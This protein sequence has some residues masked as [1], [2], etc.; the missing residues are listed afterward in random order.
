MKKSLFYFNRIVVPVCFLFLFA[1]FN[2]SCSVKSQTPT[3]LTE[4]DNL[5]APLISLNGIVDMND[6]AGSQ[7]DLVEGTSPIPA[8]GKPLI[9][10]AY[11]VSPNVIGLVVDEKA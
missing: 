2:F 7:P 1:V 6:Y 5:S 4:S 3:E 10:H 8:T 9:R 11:M